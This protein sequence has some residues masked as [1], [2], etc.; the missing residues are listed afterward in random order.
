ML[1]VVRVVLGA[2][3]TDLEMVLLEVIQVQVAMEAIVMVVMAVVLGV[4]IA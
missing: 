3:I 1:V 4:G 2:I